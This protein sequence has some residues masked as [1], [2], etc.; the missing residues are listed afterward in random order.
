METFIQKVIQGADKLAASR[1]FKDSGFM[2]NIKMI[3]LVKDKENQLLKERLP[4][5]EIVLQFSG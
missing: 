3:V 5:P 1:E 2:E 4:R